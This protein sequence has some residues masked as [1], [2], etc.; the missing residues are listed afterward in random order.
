MG[1]VGPGR[2][3]VT[4]GSGGWP[5][6]LAP[7]GPGLGLPCPRPSCS[8]RPAD[9]GSLFTGK[10]ADRLS[11]RTAGPCPLSCGQAP[12]VAGQSRLCPGGPAGNGSALA[13]AQELCVARGVG[14]VGSGRL[15]EGPLPSL[16]APQTGIGCSERGA[17][18][19]LRGVPAGPPPTS[20]AGASDSSPFGGPAH[21]PRFQSGW[22]GCICF[23]L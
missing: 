23:W 15:E 4:S 14:D 18:W 16:P 10:K 9:T 7:S 20:V 17:P 12:A 21:S 5:E 11:S 13:A 3:G 8:L 6:R 22:G 1:R 19:R 2:T